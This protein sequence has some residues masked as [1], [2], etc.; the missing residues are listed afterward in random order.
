MKTM[1]ASVLGAAAIIA[2]AAPRSASEDAA[3][4]YAHDYSAPRAVLSSEAPAVTPAVALGKSLFFDPRL[5]RSRFVS[6][7][8]CHNP[9]LSWADGNARATGDLM[10]TLGRRTPT[11]LN[12]AWAEA[13]FWDG[14]A[15]TLED[16]A[17]GPITAQ[18]EMNLT[19]DTMVARLTAI[20]GYTK[21]F[22]RAYPGEGVSG[23]TVAKA[24]A[25]FERTVISGVS[26][27]D[28]WVAGD[29][30]AI[31]DEAKQGFVVFNSKARCS[32]CHSGW[33]FTDDG[34]QDIGLPGM[35]R[36]RGGIINLADAEHAFKTPTLRDV[37]RRAPYMHDGSVATLEQ[38]VELYDKGGEVRR[39]SLSDD[40]RPLHLTAA[41]K[42]ALVAFMRTLT[43]T[44]RP[45]TLPVLPN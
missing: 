40:I 41:E 34:F 29:A 1:L 30:S 44:E 45:M 35:D 6:C 33:R 5:S 38:V 9:A 28:R 17:L 36:G 14:R 24:I 7:A 3:R 10:K 26:P 13:M 19:L 39:P 8:S 20:P 21:L 2:V 15:A 23:K 16:Q 18:A 31:S 22:E 12:L 25:A 11:I 27:F 42:H 4:R 32:Q 43:G 37:E